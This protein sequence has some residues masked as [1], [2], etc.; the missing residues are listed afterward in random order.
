[1]SRR[2][3]IVVAVV[4]VAVDILTK[5]FVSTH[6]DTSQSISLVP[7][8]VR[9]TYV[10]NTGVAFG[11]FPGQRVV[12]ITLSLL[13]LSA[14]SYYLMRHSPKT[15]REVL[16]LG[17]FIGGAVGNLIDRV[18]SGEVIDFIEVGP[19]AHP[20]PVFNV[21]DMGVTCGVA[22]LVLAALFPQSRDVEP[23]VQP[24][25]PDGEHE[26]VDRGAAGSVG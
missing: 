10:R 5:A 11:L 23:D 24:G 26:P 18:R 15:W 21:A 20:F 13:G 19:R 9:L 4:V 22:L 12:F 8:W 14:V 2:S 6:M 3:V 17:L 1:V 16:A 25:D 7:G